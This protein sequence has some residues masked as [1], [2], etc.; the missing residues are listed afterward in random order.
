MFVV[1][2]IPANSPFASEPDEPEPFD[3]SPAPAPAP[4]PPQ[5]VIE[6]KVMSPVSNPFAA[7]VP[8]A[9]P[10]PPPRPAVPPPAVAL[11]AAPA[12]VAPRPL[13]NVDFVE[14]PRT[15][16]PVAVHMPAYVP[17]AVPVPSAVSAFSAPDDDEFDAFSAKFNSAQKVEKTNIFLEDPAVDGERIFLSLLRVMN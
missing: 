12:P 9:R 8:P 5:A 4:T 10:A 16:A 13:P 15:F 1:P 17:A 11:A 7:V 14:Q 2:A 6:E 3:A